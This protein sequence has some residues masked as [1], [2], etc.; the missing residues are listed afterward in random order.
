MTKEDLKN[1]IRIKN[2]L[3]YL[4]GK[5]AELNLEKWQHYNGYDIKDDFIIINYTYSDFWHNTD[6]YTEWDSVK[7]SIDNIINQ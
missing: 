2:E 1:Y 3:N 7:V 4:C 5:W 6:M